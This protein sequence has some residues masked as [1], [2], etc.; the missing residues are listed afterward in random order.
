MP[1]PMWVAEVNKRLFNRIEL[2]RG[3][4]PV[5][6]HVGRSTGRH[7]RTPLEVQL[8]DGGVI[9][10]LMYGSESDWV[11]NV[12]AAGTAELSV[13]DDELTLTNPRVVTKEAAL[14]QLPDTMK[15]PPEFL[16]VDEYFQLD[17]A[18]HTPPV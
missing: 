3:E 16:K 6:S 7:Y 17:I 14:G 15:P 11:Q 10:V 12:L 13:G 4:R 9:I 2:R 5:L 8:I 18:E 1:M